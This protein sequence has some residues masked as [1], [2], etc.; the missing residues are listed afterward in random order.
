M[1]TKSSVLNSFLKA[2]HHHKG[3]PKVNC[4]L[5]ASSDE[6][7]GDVVESA[8]D[9][10]KQFMPTNPYSASKAAAEMYVWAYAKYFSIPS[11]VVRSNNVFGPG[12]YPE[13]AVRIL[14][15]SGYSAREI[16]Y[17]HSLGSPTV[18]ST[19]Q[20]TGSTAASWLHWDG[21]SVCLSPQNSRLSVN[22]YRKNLETW[23]P[24]V[25][26]TIDVTSTATTESDIPPQLSVN[27]VDDLCDGEVLEEPS[28]LN[29]PVVVA[30]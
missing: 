1:S 20:T 15:L 2:I 30:V 24:K 26:E 23:W 17:A 14:E 11:L 28:G 18:P 21:A 19:T 25:S 7:N 29:A 27:V 4:F 5:H 3:P 13:I 9:E 6:V 22:W 16:S 12:Q 8:C 10:A